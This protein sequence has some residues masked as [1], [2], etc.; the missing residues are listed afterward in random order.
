LF[1]RLT[2]ISRPGQPHEVPRLGFFTFS[3]WS[4]VKLIGRAVPTIRE[5]DL[6]VVL[7]DDLLNIAAARTQ[8]CAVMFLRNEHVHSDLRHQVV[9]DLQ[10][11]FLGASDTFL[12]SLQCD[13][14]TVA[15]NLREGDAHISKLISQLPQHLSAPGSEVI[16]VL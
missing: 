5:L 9:H 3:Q 14:I 16:V 15:A 11:S 6:D 12:S 7:L 4:L 2:L 10:H 1:G 13:D 8:H